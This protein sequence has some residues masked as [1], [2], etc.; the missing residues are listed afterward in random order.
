MWFPKI[1]RAMTENLWLPAVQIGF[2]NGLVESSHC[3]HWQILNIVLDMQSVR[4]ISANSTYHVL[5]KKIS[6][7]N[8][9]LHIYLEKMSAW[10][11]PFW[12]LG[13]DG[14]RDP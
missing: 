9:F 11:V 14:P 2:C 12:T 4:P 8:A 7:I 3:T 10:F 1:A 13:N 6:F 5:A